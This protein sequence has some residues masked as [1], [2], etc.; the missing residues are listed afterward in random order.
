M[1]SLT[2]YLWTD[3][4]DCRHPLMTDEFANSLT[5]ICLIG[6]TEKNSSPG[7]VLL[8]FEDMDRLRVTGGTEELG[9]SAEGQWA[10]ADI[11]DER[12][13]K[14]HEPRQDYSV[15][16]HFWFNVKKVTLTSS[17]LV[18]TQTV[19]VLQVC[20]R[21]WWLFPVME[22][23]VRLARIDFTVSSLVSRRQ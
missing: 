9:I 1:N 13:N 5:L 10:D 14:Q 7:T 11:S 6:E 8:Q 23:N 12:T 3:R 16:V 19:S 21:L 15:F 18:W 20:W 22:Q 2:F 17:S 4:E